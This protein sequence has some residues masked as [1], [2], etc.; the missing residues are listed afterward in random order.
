[1]PS[2]RSP[3][4]ANIVI[5]AVAKRLSEANGDLL[6]FTVADRIESVMAELKRMFANLDWFSAVAY[7]QMRIPTPMFTADLRHQPH[8]RLGRTRHGAAGRQQADPPGRQLYRTRQPRV[9]ADNGARMMPYLV[10]ADLPTQP[11]GER[12]RALVERGGILAIPGTHNGMAALQARRA[13]FEALYL[14]GAAMTASRDCRT[15]A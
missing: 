9:R 8:E 2:T 5:K 10:A 13:G 15:W 3:T 1:M 11:A 14:S 6:T 12:F 4:P 7:S